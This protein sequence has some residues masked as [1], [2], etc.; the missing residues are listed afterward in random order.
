MNGKAGQNQPQPYSQVNRIACVG[1]V[2]LELSAP[3]SGDVKLGV[4]G[5]TYNTAV[6]LKRLLGRSC[7]VDYVTALGTD[8]FSDR[9]LAEFDNWARQL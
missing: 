1:E 7:E 6:Y 4:A 5:D 9:I 2:M 3:A 8:A